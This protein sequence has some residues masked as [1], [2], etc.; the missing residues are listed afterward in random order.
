M[1]MKAEGKIIGS[2]FIMAGVFTISLTKEG[3]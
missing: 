3:P 2:S 1:D